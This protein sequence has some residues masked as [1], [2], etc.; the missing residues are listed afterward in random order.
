MRI[1]IQR[2]HIMLLDPDT[3]YFNIY[4][5]SGFGSRSRSEPSSLPP[6][7]P[8]SFTHNLSHL[9]PHPTFL[10]PSQFLPHPSP[11]IPHPSPTSH[12]DLIW[13]EVTYCIWSKQKFGLQKGSLCAHSR[14]AAQQHIKKVKSLRMSYCNCRNMPIL[15]HWQSTVSIECCA[16]CNEVNKI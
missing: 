7:F 2:I 11:F 13:G 8:S 5:R 16:G 9:L 10:L 3:K 14:Q 15:D 12:N 4:H 6:P 1:R